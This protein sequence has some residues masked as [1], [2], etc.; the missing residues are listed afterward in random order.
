MPPL[1]AT[2]NITPPTATWTGNSSNN[3]KT[4]GT[5]TTV[6]VFYGEGGDDTLIGYAGNDWLYGGM[7]ADY[8]SGGDH[9]DTLVG[10][11][12]NDTM[13]G[14]S[15]NDVFLLEGA[16]SVD[17]FYGGSELDIIY[18]KNSPGWTIF[19][20]IQIGY[21]QDIEVIWDASPYETY[22][23]AFGNLDLRTVALIEID[24]ITGSANADTIYGRHSTDI[25]G[26]N[27]HGLLIKGEGGNDIIFGSTVSDTIEGGTGNDQLHGLGGND[28]LTGDDGNDIFIFGNDDGLDFV[29]DFQD[30]LD[31]LSFVGTTASEFSDLSIVDVGSDVEI[32]IDSTTVTLLGVSSAALSDL[33]FLFA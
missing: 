13:Y 27:L 32:S 15:G 18:I 20:A 14:G 10:G 23:Y 31:R 28:F 21:M 8:L 24:G 9:A 2:P 25:N 12:G 5:D 4:G 22:L 33:D 17:S 19:N 3:T 11:L 7:G 1:Y 26:N 30:G 29:N 6:D 16:S